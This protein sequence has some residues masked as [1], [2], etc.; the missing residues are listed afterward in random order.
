MEGVEVDAQR[1]PDQRGGHLVELG[2]RIP[3]GDHDCV[4]RAA[5]DSVECADSGGDTRPVLGA[6]TTEELGM[7]DHDPLRAGLDVP[8]AD[9]F[10]RGPHPAGRGT[11]EVGQLGDP[12]ST[13]A[14][15]GTAAAAWRAWAWWRSTSPSPTAGQVRDCTRSSPLA[16]IRAGAC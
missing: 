2:G 7:G 4:V 12:Q 16:A 14:T 8:L 11:D 9:V 10:D 5:E 13:H 15:R 3:R 1:D 6:F